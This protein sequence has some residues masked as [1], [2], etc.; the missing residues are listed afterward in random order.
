MK[1]GPF[2]F[3]KAICILLQ[4][5]NLCCYWINFHLHLSFQKKINKRLW[6]SHFS[7][8]HTSSHHLPLGFS[9][10]PNL[11]L[12]LHPQPESRPQARSSRS[13][14]T[15]K[16]LMRVL[17]VESRNPSSLRRFDGCDGASN[18]DVK[19]MSKPGLGGT[20]IKYAIWRC[21]CIFRDMYIYIY[22]YVNSNRYVYIY[23]CVS[24]NVCIYIYVYL[25]RSIHHIHNQCKLVPKMGPPSK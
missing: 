3:T 5:T 17:K 10:I 11:N 1:N 20:Q 21:M 14:L 13:W 16:L 19:K 24:V 2:F 8:I 9:A 18:P 7:F 22:T 15:H 12:Q 6:S 25:Y 4:I 23:I